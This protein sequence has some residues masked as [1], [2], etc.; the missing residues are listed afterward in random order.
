[1]PIRIMA[2]FAATWLA[3]VVAA[4]RPVVTVGGLNPNHADLPQAVAAAVPGSILAVRP[5]TYTGFTSQKA[6]RLVMH[7]ATVLPA[8]G[9]NYTIQLQ[10]ITGSDPF[11]IYGIDSSVESATLGAVRV[12]NTLAPV[13]LEGVALFAGPSQAALDVFNA[14]AVHIARSLLVGSPGLQAQFANLILNDDIIGNAYGAG[15][16]VSDVS[17]DAAGSIFLGLGQPGLR[18]FDAVVRLASDGTAGMAVLG[19]P[20]V[21]ISALEA[22]D[23]SIYWDPSL[24]VMQSAN[25]APPLQSQVTTERIEEVPMLRAGPASIGGTATVRMTTATATAGV[26]MMGL[27]EPLPAA[28]GAVG[29]YLAPAPLMVAV[30]GISNPAGLQLTYSVPNT[31]ALRGDLFCFQG[32]TFLANG[33]TAISGPALWYLE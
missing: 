24:F 18:C 17:L 4:Q 25:G 5:G 8:P 28:I 27:L 13:I 26:I 32:I 6:L 7:S 2:S 9:S 29:I 16:I 33:T 23:C 1:M 12:N 31:P 3:S 20:A 14:G 22:F 11:V 21:P 30:S 15:A 10:N 19:T